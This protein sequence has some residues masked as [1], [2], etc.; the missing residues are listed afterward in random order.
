MVH[1]LLIYVWTSLV[2]K[3]LYSSLCINHWM[4]KEYMKR[5]LY[6]SVHLL[7]HSAICVILFLIL[8]FNNSNMN[9][10]LDMFLWYVSRGAVRSSYAAMRMV[11]SS[12]PVLVIAWEWH[13]GL[14][15]L[16]GCS[17]ALEYPTT[18]SSGPINKSLSLSLS[19]NT[20][21][22][23]H[24][25]QLVKRA[26]QGHEIDCSRSGGHGF[27]PQSGQIQDT[28]LLF[29]YISYT[30]LNKLNKHVVG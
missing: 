30:Y 13:I 22:D 6:W 29:N 7:E 27:K 26:S 14:A 25:N 9:V 3:S 24:D 28:V 8:W 18:N 17:G 15:L 16:C 5:R 11:A 2:S 4:E 12:R 20:F 10:T 19:L 23:F 1:S 21:K